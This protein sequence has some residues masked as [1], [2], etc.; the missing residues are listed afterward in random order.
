MISE[1]TYLDGGLGLSRVEG[2]AQQPLLFF[3]HHSAATDAEYP[4]LAPR[5]KHA[6]GVHFLADAF[7][8]GAACWAD[9]GAAAAIKSAIAT[10]K[11]R[12]FRSVVRS[13]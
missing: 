1:E 5:A 6:C 12:I 4:I 13:D 10:I 7:S 8:F 11:Q 2:V 9:P 3:A